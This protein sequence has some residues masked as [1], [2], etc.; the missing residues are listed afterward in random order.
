MGKPLIEAYFGGALARGLAEAGAEAMADYAKQE[1]AGLLGS[2]FPA[3]LTTLASSAWAIDPWALGSY[4][5]ASPGCA[6]M[7]AV[8]A[9]PVG[10]RVFFAGE[11]CSRHRNSTA[12]GAFETGLVAAEQALDALG[13]GLRE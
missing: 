10:D 5:Y 12:H 11:A 1:L 2:A 8:L 9:A 7:R 4:S 13:Q 6:E 3:R